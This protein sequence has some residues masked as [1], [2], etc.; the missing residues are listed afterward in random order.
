MWNFGE[1]K[2]YLLGKTQLLQVTFQLPRTG[3]Y[4]FYAR[5]C[6]KPETD[7]T[8]ECSTYAHSMLA[9]PETGIPYGQVEDPNNPGTYIQGKWMIYGHVAAPTGGGVD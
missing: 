6:D 3:L 7:S 9:D 8:R 2:K 4:I 1:E 5:A